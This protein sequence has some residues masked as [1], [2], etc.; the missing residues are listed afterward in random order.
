MPRTRVNSWAM[1]FAGGGPGCG[2]GGPWAEED[3]P[4]P[5]PWPGGGGSEEAI[6]DKAADQI[7]SL[8]E[9]RGRAQ[10]EA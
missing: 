9:V 6:Y 4:K 7:R 2:A 1:K 3:W 5:P 10:E 8:L